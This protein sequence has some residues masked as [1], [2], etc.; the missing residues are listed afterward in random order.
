MIGF[1][2]VED[3]RK[4]LHLLEFLILYIMLF[5]V[6]VGSAILCFSQIHTRAII[7]NCTIDVLSMAVCASLLCIV[8]M[9]G[10]VNVGI[11]KLVIMCVLEWLL[12]LV[13]FSSNL[14]IDVKGYGWVLAVSKYGYYMISSIMVYAYWRFMAEEYGYNMGVKIPVACYLAFLLIMIA[15]VWTGIIFTLDVDV[16]TYSR[17]S[18]SFIVAIPAT[19]LLLITLFSVRKAVHSEERL[20]MYFLFLLPLV[21]FVIQLFNV[22]V[23]LIGVFFLIASIFVLGKYFFKRGRKIDDQAMLMEANRMKPHFIFNSI[24]AI[25]NVPGNPDETKEALLAFSSYLRSNMDF[26]TKSGLTTFEIEM[27]NVEAY[28]YLEKI[29][30]KDRLVMEYELKEKGFTLPAFSI[31]VLVENS[32]QHGIIPRGGIGHVKVETWGDDSNIYVRVTDDG[33]GY[34]TKK[35]VVD[36]NRSHIGIDSLQE[37]IVKMSKGT[38]DVHSIIGVGTVSTI[39]LPRVVSL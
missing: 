12:L 27:D 37:R 23:E 11:R 38:L 15:N 14:F 28:V 20:F 30:L 13:N 5:S 26:M 9:N 21:A 25:M 22:D 1:K 8:M 29:R 6:L 35:R 18:V 39:T 17:S 10:R 19:I 16:C 7:I 32:I 33:V 36:P 4:R 24:G 34:D 2:Y 3:N 31:E